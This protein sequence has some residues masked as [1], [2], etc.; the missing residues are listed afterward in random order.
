M[1]QIL[2]FIIVFA[3]CPISIDFWLPHFAYVS[4][5]NLHHAQTSLLNLSFQHINIWLYIWGKYS[6]QLLG[7]GTISF[8]KFLCCVLHIADMQQ[9]QRYAE[10]RT[11][12]NSFNFHSMR[13]QIFFQL[14][15]I[16][17][18]FLILQQFNEIKA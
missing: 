10:C 1:L 5:Y 12:I 8:F 16:H 7:F 14:E 2:Q 3:A 6:K 13:A 4:V 17:Q 15:K 11:K 9:I 18:Y